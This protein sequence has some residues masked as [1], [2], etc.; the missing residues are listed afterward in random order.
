MQSLQPIVAALITILWMRTQSPK[1]TVTRPLSCV[2]STIAVIYEIFHVFHLVMT[3]TVYLDS[4]GFG[5]TTT[6]T[7]FQSISE[8]TM[9]V[10][11]LE[12][13][14]GIRGCLDTLKQYYGCLKDGAIYSGDEWVSALQRYYGI[15]DDMLCT[16]FPLYMSFF[17][18]STLELLLRVMGSLDNGTK[19]DLTARFYF[20]D[21]LL[22]F[23]AIVAL[24]ALFNVESTLFPDSLFWE[25]NGIFSTKSLE[26]QSILALA[27]E[28]QF[29]VYLAPGV[30]LSNSF[31]HVFFGTFLVSY[32]LLAIRIRLLI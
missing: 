25:T 17:V 3:A 8:L 32:V 2:V 20:T 26:R 6:H 27:A 23:L 28:K 10:V 30:R 31:I 15:I 18:G 4:W 22:T 19:Y 21:A 14:C 7:L 5:L 1:A 9:D 29:A 24:L 12:L 13:V 11:F 16:W